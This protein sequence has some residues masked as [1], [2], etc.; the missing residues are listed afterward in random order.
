MS[1]TLT[2]KAARWLK[3]ELQLDHG[4]YV[5]FYVRYGGMNGPGNGFSLGVNVTKPVQVG[6]KTVVDDT[7]FFV[8]Q[9]DVWF[10]QEYDLIIQYN[11]KADDIEFV[12]K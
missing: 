2:E 7:T 5:R 3:R 9:D 10:L 11:D 12:Y 6:E 4:D 1:F 8:E